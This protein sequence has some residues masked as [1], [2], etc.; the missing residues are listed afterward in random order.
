MVE[1]QL[2]KLTARVRF[3]SPA[4]GIA[5]VDINVN[6]NITINIST[7]YCVFNSCPHSSVGRAHPW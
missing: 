6:I 4:P 2:P 3:P 5:N 7:R 1:Y